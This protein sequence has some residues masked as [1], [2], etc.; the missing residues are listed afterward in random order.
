MML[1]TRPAFED[2]EPI[3]K[4]YS[5]EGE[6]KNPALK[7]T[8]VPPEAQSLALIMDDPDA[9]R[10]V[11]L[12]WLIWNIDPRAEAIPEGFKV[13]P[14]I[15]E[16]KNGSGKK[17]YIGPCPPPGHGIHHYRFKLYALDGRLAR[18]EN[19]SK[20]Y[21]E[22]EIQAHQIAKAELTGT[23]ERPAAA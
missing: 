20:D 2:S 12:H 5:C 23:Y 7:I 11:F 19:A 21:L 8:D 15:T 22:R 6:N 9:P 10:G 16:G 13:P 1:I 14:Q 17:G 18:D 4:I 3:P